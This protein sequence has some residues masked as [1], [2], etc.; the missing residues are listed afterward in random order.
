M[1]DLTVVTPPDTLLTNNISFLLVY[2]SRDI[3][4]DFQNLIVRFKEPFTVY[5]YEI[6][7]LVENIETDKE[8]IKKDVLHDIDWLLKH[9]HIA[10]NVIID[11]DNCPPRIKDLASYI[12]ANT[13]TF[14]LTNSTDRYYNKLSN[15]QI[16]HLDYLVDIIGAQLESKLSQTP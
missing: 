6:P 16:Y 4:D 5:V 11:L 1:S 13:N 3:K 8:T 15:K 7:D 14:W 9:C 2:P 12:I 10:D